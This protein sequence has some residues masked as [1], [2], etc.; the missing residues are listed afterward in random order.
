MPAHV[1]EAK[2]VG[3]NMH[4]CPDCTA[5]VV[6]LARHKEENCP[7]RR[8]LGG[9]PPA[10]PRSA[11]LKGFYIYS[12]KLLFFSVVL[13]PPSARERL[14]SLQRGWVFLLLLLLGLPLPLRGGP[15][16]E[17]GRSSGWCVSWSKFII[18]RV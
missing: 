11:E 8:D 7:N 10:A 4:T 17:W 13:L 3:R 6:N 1:A 18:G 5:R 12:V 15:C 9:R 16:P 2:N 14:P